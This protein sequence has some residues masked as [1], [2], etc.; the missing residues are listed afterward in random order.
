MGWMATSLKTLQSQNYDK[1]ASQTVT[2][3]KNVSAITL[4]KSGKYWAILS[5][6]RGSEFLPGFFWDSRLSERILA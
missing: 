1:L 5:Q 3:L 2:N 6:A 4:R